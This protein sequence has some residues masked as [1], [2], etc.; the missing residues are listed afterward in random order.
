MPYLFHRNCLLGNVSLSGNVSYL[1]SC[2]PARVYTGIVNS[3]QHLVVCDSSFDVPTPP[4]SWIR[5]VFMLAGVLYRF[6]SD[7]ALSAPLI[8][9]LSNRFQW[10][11]NCVALDELSLMG[12]RDDH[13]RVAIW[14]ECQRMDMLLTESRIFLYRRDT[15]SIDASLA[16]RAQKLTKQFFPLSRQI[17][18]LAFAATKRCL[19]SG[20]HHLL[21]P[22]WFAAA[23]VL[24]VEMVMRRFEK[25]R[26]SFF[27]SATVP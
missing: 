27:R 15:E 22:P 19:Q 17:P 26:I 2:L 8:A 13:S 14:T 11:I 4:Y 3:N 6:R 23:G 24:T 16:A 20:T 9:D 7:G 1:P 21:G 18:G 10:L 12:K 25:P 5:I